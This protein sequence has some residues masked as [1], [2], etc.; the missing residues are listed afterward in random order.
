MTTRGIGTSVAEHGLADAADTVYVNGDSAI[1]DAKP[2]EP[3]VQGAHVRR[4]EC[5]TVPRQSREL[6]S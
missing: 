1:P 3:D 5:L 4:R 6:G 2:I